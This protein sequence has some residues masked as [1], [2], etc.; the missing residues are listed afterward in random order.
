MLA[1]FK[2]VKSTLALT[3]FLVIAFPVITSRGHSLSQINNGSGSQN[4]PAPQVYV[5][6]LLNGIRPEM[7]KIP[8]GQFLIGSPSR[9]SGR[10][11]DE[12]FQREIKLKSFFMSRHE[13]TQDLWRTVAN[14]PKSTIELNPTPSRFKGDDLP[15]ENV[16]WLEVKEFFA[17]L[18]HQLGLNDDNGYRLPTEAEWEYAARAGSTT[19]FAFGETISSSIVNYRA[20]GVSTEEE[21]L[22]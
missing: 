14:L 7:V 6:D 8:D 22:K 18:N 3:L 9:E 19:P 15:V 5:E 2:R 1:E 17:R 20:M 12:D 11:N 4:P 10:R 21:R 13:V 16:S